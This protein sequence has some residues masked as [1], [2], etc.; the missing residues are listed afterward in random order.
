V[1]PLT[2]EQL[3]GALQRVTEFQDQISEK[4]EE[5]KLYYKSLKERGVDLVMFKQALKLRTS[6]TFAE[7]WSILSADEEP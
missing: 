4:E 2:R 3:D 1:V 5:L 7:Y 6:D